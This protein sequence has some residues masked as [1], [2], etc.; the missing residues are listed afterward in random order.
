MNYATIIFQKANKCL[1]VAAP[2]G[3]ERGSTYSVKEKVQF[4]DL[5]GTRGGGCEKKIFV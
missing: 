1:S 5:G 4:P 3:R 2:D